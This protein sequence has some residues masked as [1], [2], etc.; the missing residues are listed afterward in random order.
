[1]CQTPPTTLR[2]HGADLLLGLALLAHLQ[3]RE[4]VG[5]GQKIDGKGFSYAPE[6]RYLQYRRPAETTVRE[7]QRCRKAHLAQ[8]DGRFQGHARQPVEFS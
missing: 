3:V 1:L 7:Q 2:E 5:A 8:L 6:G 4:H